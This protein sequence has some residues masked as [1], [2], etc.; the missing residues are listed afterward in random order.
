MA[1]SD[2]VH[3]ILLLQAVVFFALAVA[4]VLRITSF[5]KP[6][7]RSPAAARR[8]PAS[9]QRHF[10]SPQCLPYT[11]YGAIPRRLII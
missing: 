7:R 4:V 2:A 1:A 5:P 9:A 11:N 8:A 10:C 6:R 3:R